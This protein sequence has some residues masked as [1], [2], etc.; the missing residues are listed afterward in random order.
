MV[1]SVSR[2]P[3]QRSLPPRRTKAQISLGST[4]F[5]QRYLLTD[6]LSIFKCLMGTNKVKNGVDL[7]F[8]AI[9]FDKVLGRFSYWDNIFLR[10][11]QSFGFIKQF[12]SNIGNYHSCPNITN[13]LKSI[14]T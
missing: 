12:L 8:Q 2:L 10:Y 6:M 14:E 3:M 4:N 9:L 5:K 1:F 7:S 13:N 11:A